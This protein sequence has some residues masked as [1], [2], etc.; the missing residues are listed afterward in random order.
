[1][2]GH[3]QAIVYIGPL[4]AGSYNFF[5]DFNRSMQGT[6]VVKPAADTGKKN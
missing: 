6:I 5:N 1:M 3:G 4:K 2:A